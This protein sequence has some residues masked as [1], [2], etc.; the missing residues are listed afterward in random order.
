MSTHN[1]MIIDGVANGAI[2]KGQFVKYAAGGWVA[3]SSQ[4]ERA[5][6]VAFSDASGAGAA[7]AVQIG[8]LVKY[9]VGASPISDAA[10]ITTGATG[11]GETAGAGDYTRLKAIGAGAAGAY[12][13]ALWCDDMFDGT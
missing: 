7:V 13:E 8:G 10:K 5:D 6:G 3:C 12:A 4:G 2:V 9:K 1:A 11:L